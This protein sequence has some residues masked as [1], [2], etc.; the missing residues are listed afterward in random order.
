MPP[1]PQMNFPHW[2]QPPPPGQNNNHS[3][4]PIPGTS[5]PP[6]PGTDMPASSSYFKGG[7]FYN[8]S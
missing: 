6:P 2:G 4:P 5:V 7:S 8:Y 1:P 3:N